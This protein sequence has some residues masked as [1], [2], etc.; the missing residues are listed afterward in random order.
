MHCVYCESLEHTQ[1]SQC[2]DYAEAT[3]KGLVHINEKN[4]VVNAMMSEE[5]PT[6]FGHGGMKKALEQYLASIKSRLIPVNNNAITLDGL[7]RSAGNR[8]SVQL[9]TFHPNGLVEY[10]SITTDIKERA[11]DLQDV[12]HHSNKHHSVYKIQ[13]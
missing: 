5:L 2:P 7:L 8:N 4:H 9:T 12:G 6:A 3:P 10:E 11:E 1:R 13:L